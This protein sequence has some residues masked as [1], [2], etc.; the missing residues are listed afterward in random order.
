MAHKYELSQTLAKFMDRH[1]VFPILEFHQEKGIYEARDI[2]E[3]KLALLKNT[4]MVDFAMD[5]YKVLNDTEEVPPAMAQHR[6]EVVARLRKL[7]ADVD[8]IIKC[9]ENPSVVRN[10]RQDKAFNLQFLQ[11][12]FQIGPDHVEALFQYAKFQFDC[13]NYS[14]A[15]EL[16]PPYRTLC[17]NG[18]RNMAALWGKLSSDILMQNFEAA[19]DDI[20]KLKDAI[21]NATFAA[22]LVQLQQRTWLLHWS[23]FVFWNHE[24]GRSDLI[25]LFMRRRRNAMKDLIRVIQQEA[26]EYSDPVTSFLEDLFVHYDFD[27][28]QH[29]LAECEAVIDNDFFLTAFKDDFVESARLFIFEIYC[30]IHQ[31]I[32]IKMLA[33]RLNMDLEAAEKWIANL[34]RSVR[35]NAKIDSQ[36][37]TVVMGSQTQSVHEQII[38]KTKQL[39]E[40]GV[41]EQI[42]GSHV[43]GSEG[44]RK[45]LRGEADTHLTLTAHTLSYGLSAMHPT[46]DS[47]WPFQAVSAQLK[48]AAVRPCRL[49]ECPT[50]TGTATLSASSCGTARLGDTGPDSN[51]LIGD[52][53]ICGILHSIRLS[54]ASTLERAC[55]GDCR[56]RLMRAS[57][58]SS[59]RRKHSRGF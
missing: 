50:C 22:P 7:Q 28:A 6:S 16:L 49:E 43:E 21:D 56:S 41:S 10:F 15:A 30:R 23:L 51:V 58:P 37:G 34:I 5:I 38:E 2:M 29:K 53:I 9:L 54:S 59:Q 14:V 18:E 20:N 36:S 52:R 55:R 33:E 24:N 44:S 26:Y 32:D 25:D 12:D 35:L 46:V 57:V 45:R 1:L 4:N 11:E 31:C 47:T 42:L 39:S 40:L 48:Q 19:R 17:T 3:A 13:G 8:P 27:G